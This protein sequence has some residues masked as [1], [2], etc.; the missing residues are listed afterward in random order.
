[1]LGA[2]AV[3]AVLNDYRSYLGFC[4]AT[5]A[6][7]L[8]QAR[9]DRGRRVGAPL[10]V[11][12]LA[13]C[14]YLVY[15]LV[16]VLLLAG[17][18][19]YELQQRTIN[20]VRQAGSLLLGGRPEWQATIQLMKAFPTGV[21]VGAEPTSGDVTLAKQGLARV[22]LPTKNGYIDHYM[23]GGQFKLHSVVAD[24]WS[25]FGLLGLLLGGVVS[26]TLLLSLTSAMADRRAVA[27]VVFLA[28]T[29][30]WDMA[31]GP[32]YSSLPAIA[33]ALG[34]L[35]L[36]RDRAARAAPRDEPLRLGRDRAPADDAG[37][38]SQR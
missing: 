1:V 3:L 12:L 13:V 10:Q 36:P 16:T 20:Q 19:G 26:L 21:G 4:A 2:L 11:L 8:W 9:P 34:L 25:N 7:M 6:L 18:F 27:L 23:F 38:A 29:A 33:P 32:I 31:F 14:A 17:T 22:G 30:L 37:A 35:L 24:M 15:R 28:L 5:V